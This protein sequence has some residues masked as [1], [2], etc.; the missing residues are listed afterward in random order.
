MGYEQKY[1]DDFLI[2]NDDNQPKNETEEALVLNK[3]W[4]ELK[5]EWYSN[6]GIRFEIAKA[7]S[8]RETALI[9][10]TNPNKTLRCLK[11][12]AVKYLDM[13]NIRYNIFHE[14]FNI[15]GS[16]AKYPNLPVFSFSAVI[17]T[18]Q[19]K[20]FNKEYKEIM[21]SFDFM[22]DIDNE[23][24]SKALSSLK[25]ANEVFKKYKVP[26]WVLFSGTKGF[27]IRVDYE[28]FPQWLKDMPWQEVA[29]ILK[30]FAENFKLLNALPDID[31]V[32][33]DLRRIAKTPYSVVYPYYFIALP[34][35]DNAIET[36]DLEK[37]SLPYCI[38]NINK[39]KN[40]GLLKR[41]GSSEGFGK[42]LKEYLEI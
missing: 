17:K 30:N 41:N 38:K 32:V 18:T 33:Y 26:Y 14:T 37:V 9:H 10:Y 22:M 12:N 40:R 11:I 29:S 2:N 5:L 42:L 6:L 31:L 23:D 27:H 19:Q 4:E 16:L 28:D 36:F 21:S 8:Y 13:N 39:Y 15:Y 7:I 35:S 20:K 24:I 3:D 25:V 1:E 34:L